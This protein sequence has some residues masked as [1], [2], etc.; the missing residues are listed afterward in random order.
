MPCFHVVCKPG[1]W[2]GIGEFDLYILLITCHPPIT[3]QV[4]P[5]NNSFL[6]AC[7]PMCVGAWVRAWVGVWRGGGEIHT[8]IMSV[9]TY[10]FSNPPYRWTGPPSGR[11][12]GRGPGCGSPRGHR[13]TP[14]SR[15]AL[16]VRP[17]GASRTPGGP[18][19]Q[20]WRKGPKKTPQPNNRA[21]SEM[22]RGPDRR[23]TQNS[24]KLR[25]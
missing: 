11:V 14:S 22:R 9:I 21:G 1:R 23:Y 5:T 12:R 7:M 24:A 19:G 16:R 3:G 6:C 17:R 18:N 25:P 4:N 20:Q 13:G 2:S 8:Y 15:G 10:T